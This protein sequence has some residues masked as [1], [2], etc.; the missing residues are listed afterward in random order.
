MSCLAQRLQ[1][2]VKKINKHLK[3]VGKL[4]HIFFEQAPA[5]LN[6]YTA[7]T[8]QAHVG[9]RRPQPGRN[10]ADDYPMDDYPVDDPLEEEQRNHADDEEQE[11]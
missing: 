6:D 11:S 8:L 2:R 5:C 1:G 7:S 9:C 3:E 4:L 10:H